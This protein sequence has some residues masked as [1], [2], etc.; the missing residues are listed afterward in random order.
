MMS[1]KLESKK[2]I[3]HP[4]PNIYHIPFPFCQRCPWGRDNYIQCGEWC[5]YK[6]LDYLAN[7][8]VDNNHIAGFMI[9]SYQ[10]WG[11]IFYPK[12]YIKKVKM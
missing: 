6:G 8:G 11:A 5:F 9:E 4:D 3:Q 7:Q 10:G 12:D 2:W 1:G